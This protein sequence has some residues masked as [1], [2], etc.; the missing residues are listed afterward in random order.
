MNLHRDP[1]IFNAIINQMQ[2]EVSIHRS[3]IIK[4]YFVTLFLKELKEFYP[5]YIFKGGTSLSKC[6][7]A[8]NRFSEDVDL[9]YH[10]SGDDKVTASKIK[11]A[12]KGIKK[13]IDHLGFTFMNEVDFKS[14]RKFQL[15]EIGVSFKED[16][17]LVRNHIIV[18][19]SVLTIA[20]PIIEKD[21][22]SLIAR[23]LKNVNRVDI[24]EQYELQSFKVQVQDMVRTFIDKVYAICDYYLENNPREHSRHIYD[25]H[26]IY[27]KIGDLG[28]HIELIKEV[29][30]ERMSNVKSISILED[31]NIGE[32]VER[33][34]AEEFYKKDYHDITRNLL[35]DDTTYDQVIETLI[36]ISK[37]SYF[38]G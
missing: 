38:N 17:T 25:I 13:A 6:F 31:R 32:L 21:I 12:N 14:G 29:R 3:I 22:E 4:D 19:N 9:S 26:M 20:F 33:I 11:R 30:K 27:D 1:K 5:E 34:V 18:E 37:V 8:I 36:S 23:Y 10:V 2:D 24:I 35:Y 15:Y 16:D 28:N 7:D